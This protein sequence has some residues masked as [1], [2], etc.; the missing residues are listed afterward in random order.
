MEWNC[1]ILLILLFA[2]YLNNFLSD[3]EVEIFYS[4]KIRGNWT[5]SDIQKLVFGMEVEVTIPLLSDPICVTH[6]LI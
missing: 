1:N 3:H 6:A 2:D 5:W 4:W